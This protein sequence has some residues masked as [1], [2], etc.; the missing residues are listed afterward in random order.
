MDRPHRDRDGAY[1]L[2][3]C[4]IARICT[5]RIKML[6]G[7]SDDGKNSWTNTVTHLIKS[8]SSPIDSAKGSSRFAPA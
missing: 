6:V 5:I 2:L 3:P 4:C 8:S 7:R 1:F